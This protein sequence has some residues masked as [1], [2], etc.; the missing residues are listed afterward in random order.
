MNLWQI[1]CEGVNWVHRKQ[2]RN[3]W[4]TLVNMILNLTF[5]WRTGNLLTR[6]V[7]ISVSRRTPFNG[8]RYS[9][10]FVPF[11]LLVVTC[12]TLSLIPW[13][14]ADSEEL[15]GIWEVPGSNLPLGTYYLNSG[16]SWFP[17]IPPGKCRVSALLKGH[18]ISYTAL[19]ISP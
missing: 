2:D 6:W 13:H 16:F 18:S 1:G 15:T 19:Y 12:R 11:S 14:R 17:I 9:P 10:Y 8:I 7:I 3:Q 4:R 5:L